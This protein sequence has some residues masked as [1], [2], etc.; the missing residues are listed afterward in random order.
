MFSFEPKTSAGNRFS[1]MTRTSRTTNPSRSKRARRQATMENLENRQLLTIF[2]LHPIAIAPLPV[3]GNT[4]TGHNVAM[5]ASDEDIPGNLTA[6]VAFPSGTTTA[7][8]V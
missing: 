1:R 6:S 7:T 4:F 5:F 8:V 3:E 2:N